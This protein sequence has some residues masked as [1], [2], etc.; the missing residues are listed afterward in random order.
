MESGSPPSLV[1]TPSAGRTFG[2]TSVASL[3]VFRPPRTFCGLDSGTVVVGLDHPTLNPEVSET[4]VKDQGWPE[5]LRVHRVNYFGSFPSPLNCRES[6]G[7]PLSDGQGVGEGDSGGVHKVTSRECSLPG[8]V[9]CRPCGA[10]PVTPCLTVHLSTGGR[11]RT[12]GKGLPPVEGPPTGRHSGCRVSLDGRGRHP[13]G[14]SAGLDQFQKAYGEIG[15][16]SPR[17]LNYEVPPRPDPD[18]KTLKT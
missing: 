6:P 16:L 12:W 13:S 14:E 4:R 11:R 9:L 10:V 17:D 5:T 15:D 1:L 7:V 8:R 18:L 2:R 3:E